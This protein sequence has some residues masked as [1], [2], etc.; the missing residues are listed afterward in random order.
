MAKEKNDR[1]TYFWQQQAASTVARDGTS[2]TMAQGMAL[3]PWRV[4]NGPQAAAPQ[5]AAPSEVATVAGA[6]NAATVGEW[7]KERS[8]ELLEKMRQLCQDMKLAMEKRKEQEDMQVAT[9]KRRIDE[10]EAGEGE[11]MQVATKK[12]QVK[13]QI[14]EAINNRAQHTTAQVQ[15]TSNAFP[16]RS[17]K[18]ELSNF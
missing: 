18:R 11:V 3:P 15:E 6:G 17:D 8:H 12:R 7:A 2:I 10:E 4:W 5:A 16:A 9:K 13:R 1:N 14:D